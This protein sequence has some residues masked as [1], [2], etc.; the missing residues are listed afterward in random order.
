M[1]TYTK[2][3]AK[4]VGYVQVIVLTGIS[5]GRFGRV[6]RPGTMLPIQIGGRIVS[7]TVLS[8][9][10]TFS[11]VCTIVVVID[12]LLVLTVNMNFARSV[13]AI[14]SDVKGVKPKLKDYNPTCS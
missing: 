7:P 3:A 14:V 1:N 9:M 6:M 2:D 4:N 12:M 11:F 8:A 13:K 10:L 5:Q